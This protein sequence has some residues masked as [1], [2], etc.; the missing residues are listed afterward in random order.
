MGELARR[1]AARKPPLSGS[2]PDR[3]GRRPKF[4]NIPRTYNGREY[5]SQKEARY[6]A[7]LDL[8]CKAIGPHRIN[9]WLPQVPVK[10]E[11]NGKLVTTYI[12][13][14]LVE[15]MDGRWE[16]VEVKG[17]ETPEWR[18]KEKLFRALFPDRQLTIVR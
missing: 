13:D 14:F 16:Y 10:L 15:H 8:R 11:V 1:R 3:E 2:L 18:I 4:G 6:A 17:F 7:E 9:R 5:H 12:V